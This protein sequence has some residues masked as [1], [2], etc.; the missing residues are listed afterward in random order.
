MYQPNSELTFGQCGSA[1]TCARRL[2][3]RRGTQ[4]DVPIEYSTALVAGGLKYRCQWVLR[5]R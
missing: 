2:V 4:I 3:A 5:Q 1:T